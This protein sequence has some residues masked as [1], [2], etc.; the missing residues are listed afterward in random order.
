MATDHDDAILYLVDRHGEGRVSDDRFEQPIRTL[1]SSATS[2]YSYNGEVFENER[3][4]LLRFLD[5][6]SAAE[7]FGSEVLALWVGV[8]QDPAVRGGLHT[9]CGRERSHAALLAQRLEALG[10]S[11]TA[12]LSPQL[13]NA[14]RERLASIEVSDAEKLRDLVVRYPDVEA[15]VKPIRDVIA[16]IDDDVETK[17][18]LTTILE[19]E[20]ATLRWMLAAFR[21]CSSPQDPDIPLAES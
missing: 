20:V 14:A 6:F 1:V 19:D 5:D 18:L 4:L 10:G 21:L 16:Q 3:A 17:A 15:G 13:R 11:C 9:I 8:A 7:R 2:Q 12:E